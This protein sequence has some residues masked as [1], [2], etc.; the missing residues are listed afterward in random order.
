MIGDGWKARSPW[1]IKMCQQFNNDAQK[2]AQELDVSFLGSD[3]TV[4]APE[5][6]QMQRDLNVREPDE[7]L[8][9]PVLEDTW[10]WKAPYEGHKYLMSIDN[11]R[12]SSDDATALE[13][14]DLSGI[15]DDGLPLST[16]RVH[17]VYEE[18]Y[19]KIERVATV[20]Y[21]RKKGAG[22]LAILEAEAWIKD[23]GF[24]KIL[25]SSREEALGFYQK[26]GYE[27]DNTKEKF[28][29]GRF[30]CLWIYKNI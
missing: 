18:G 1:Y 14:I 28:G 17:P 19:A 2:I 7:T 15:D 24:S 26:L 10:V 22:K 20:S 25:I 5:F 6:I 11:S 9:D 23:L 21:A 29:G 13:I 4:V 27:V 3:S 16:C 12:G 30:V 8:R